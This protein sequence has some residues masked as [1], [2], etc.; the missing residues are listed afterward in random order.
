M[1]VEKERVRILLPPSP[2]KVLIRFLD[3]TE[4]CFH[5]MRGSTL[6]SQYYSASS[7]KLRIARS[8]IKTGM[9]SEEKKRRPQT[10]AAAEISVTAAVSPVSAG[11]ASPS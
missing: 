9:F 10:Y 2:F 11:H 5:P 8:G 4:A 3:L 6:F 1:T 7:P